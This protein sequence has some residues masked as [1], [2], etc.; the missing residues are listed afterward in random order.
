[1]EFP[2]L[3]FTIIRILCSL[4]SF[5]I[6]FPVVVVVVTVAAAAAHCETANEEC[7]TAKTTDARRKA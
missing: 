3:G 4:R 1:M 5:V 6:D 7:A 2:P